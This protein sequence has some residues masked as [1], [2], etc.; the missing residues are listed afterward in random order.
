MRSTAYS[1]RPFAE[2]VRADNADMLAI[3]VV[4]DLAVVETLDRLLAEVPVDAVM[5]GPGDLSTAL[6]L[7]GQPTHPRVRE[8]VGRIVKAARRGGARVGMYLNSPAEV[9]E[10]KEEEFDFFIYLF[11]YK[12]LA[13]AYQSVSTAIRRHMMSPVASGKERG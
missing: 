1:L 4:E 3:G 8:V 13:Q 10:W 2:C 7:P 6:G 9:E 11:D 12:V 5:P